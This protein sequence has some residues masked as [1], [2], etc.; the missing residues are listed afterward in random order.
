MSNTNPEKGDNLCEGDP[1]VHLNAYISHW[2]KDFHT[3]AKGYKDAADFL[4]QGIINE[5]RTFNFQIN[6]LVFPVVFLYTHY[7]ELRLK[8]IILLS[9]RL[10]KKSPR[11]PDALQ[12]GHEIDKLWSHAKP[13]IKAVSL[14]IS[15]VG[16]EDVEN[17]IRELVAVDPTGM[18]FRY[19]K[20]KKGNFH[21]PG[22]AV[23]DLKHLKETMQKMDVLDGYSES[24]EILWQG[25]A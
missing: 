8:D 23:I 25:D 18:A 21:H 10:N 13:L 12:K 6:E 17:G 1:D 2:N 19:P 7:I 9:N 5:P 24:L 3:Y 16:L 22:L 11:L 15:R 20:D 14:E 4:V